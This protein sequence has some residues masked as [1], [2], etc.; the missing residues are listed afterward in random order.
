MKRYDEAMRD[1]NLAV[2]LD[3]YNPSLRRARAYLHKDLSMPKE[4]LADINAALKY[5]LYNHHNWRA[6]GYILLYKNNDFAGAEAAFARAVELEPMNESS[7]YE[8]GVAQ[9]KQLSCDFMT[10]MEVY[11][12]LCKTKKCDKQ[13]TDWSAS[14][15][16]MAINK[17]FCE[18]MKTTKPG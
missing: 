14:V 4:D 3:E 10:P 11:L 18:K 1:L 7:W 12:D 9:Y 15:L 8:L 13:Y 6:K 17:D 2:S 16:K 5:G